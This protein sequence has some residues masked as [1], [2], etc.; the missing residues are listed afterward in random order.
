MTAAMD[1]FKRGKK[2]WKHK[3]QEA[4]RENGLI[5]RAYF[6]IGRSLT[7]ARDEIDRLKRRVFELE[8]NLRDTVRA[9]A[10][11]ADFND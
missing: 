7:D 2:Y 3:Y 4:E 6:D 10:E 11:D 9:E 5:W 8:E 1:K